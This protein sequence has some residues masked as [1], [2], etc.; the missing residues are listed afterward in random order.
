MDPFLYQYGIGLCIFI[1]GIFYAHKQG[2]V[3]LQGQGLRNS[4]ILL[5]GMGFFAGVQGYL[6]YAPMKEATPQTY[7]C[8]DASD[9]EACFSKI[10]S[11]DRPPVLQALSPEERAK[12]QE[13]AANIKQRKQ[14]KTLKKKRKSGEITELE[15][16]QQHSSI[17]RKKMGTNLDYGIM[18]GYFLAMLGIGT[19]FGRGQATTKDFFFGGQRFSWWMISFSLV[20]TTIGSYSFVKYS[21]IA[22]K[23]GIAS[24]QT[25]MN[26]W[27]WVPL[28]L[29][30]WLPILYFSRIVSIPE[31]FEKRFGRSARRVA[32]IILLAY[33]IGYV[34]VNL[35]TMGQALNILLG[36][37]IFWAATAVASISAVYVT[38]GGQ[39]SVIMTDLFQGFMLLLT[40]MILLVLG[41]SYLGGFDV[42]WEYL[43]RSHRLAFPAFNEAEG[44]YGDKSYPA[45]GI[46]WQDA[47]ANSAMFYFLNQGMVMR[48]MAAKSIKDSRK[49]V[50]SMLVILMPI[51]ALVVAS[52][53]WVGKSLAGAGVL[54]EMEPDTAFFVAAEFLAVPGVFGLIMAALTAALMSTVDTLVTAVSAIVVNDLY[55]PLR[56]KATER[57]LLRMAR[58]SA[59]SVSI[60]GVL[61]VP[62]FMEFDSIYAAHG[63]FTAA[64]TPPL[65][66]TLLLGVFWKRFTPFAALCTMVGGS[67]IIFGSILYPDMIEPFAQGVGKKE[68][69]G[70]LAGKSQYKFMRAFFGILCCSGIAIVST[71]M[72][73]PK[74]LEEIKGFVWGTISSAIAFYKGSAGSESESLVCTVR[75]QRGASDEIFGQGQLPAVRVSKI[76]AQKL[77]A[78]AKDL[79]Y[80]SDTRWWLGGLR[81]AHAIIEEVTEQDEES[82]QLSDPL[83]A[84]L[85]NK[86]ETGTITVQRLY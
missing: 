9:F 16:Q 55:K 24:S 86:K 42:F 2:Y 50:I 76:L 81:S 84:L 31:Y 30:G 63:A 71:Y 20:A 3:S 57:E 26:D 48:L 60:L 40:G 80:I 45:V 67:M 73:K 64:I 85:L 29:F 39:T 68:A 65:V 32:T 43:P 56:P 69:S 25:Y 34:G 51:A 49:A 74:P 38:F 22:Y 13:A 75:A 27:F 77:D 14:S 23:Y 82:I 70:F 54:P 18:I 62:I 1:I 36:W 12:T 19:W 53:G 21:K 41:M 47:M 66:V 35:F 46:F 79:V 61:L 17:Q 78:Q 72:S 8:A 33:L 4:I 44:I 6:Q 5:A 37:D 58:I 28:L 11:Q 10:P 52:G 7:P 59:L 83:H 15:Y